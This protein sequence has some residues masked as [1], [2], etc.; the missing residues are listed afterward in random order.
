MA[1]RYRLI[2]RGWFSSEIVKN[3]LEPVHIKTASKIMV[4]ITTKRKMELSLSSSYALSIK[5]G[6]LSPEQMSLSASCLPGHRGGSWQTDG[7]QMHTAPRCS[8]DGV[9]LSVPSICSHFL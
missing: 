5:R 3:K 4:S 9:L 1:E 2:L 6:W 7:M 8:K